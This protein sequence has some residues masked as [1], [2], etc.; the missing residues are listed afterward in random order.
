MTQVKVLLVDDEHEFV[1]ALA[2]RLGRRNLGARIATSGEQALQQIQ[3]D[4][5]DVVVVDL[6]MPGMDG[7]DIVRR[8]KALDPR[9]E[10]VALTGE[11]WGKKAREVLQLGALRCLEKPLNFDELLALIISAELSDPREGPA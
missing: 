4:I 9:I 8:I 3:K 11:P 6:N 2:R 10:V 5:P 7:P 1:T